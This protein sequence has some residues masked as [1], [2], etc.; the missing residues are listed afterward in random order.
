[1]TGIATK[2]AGVVPAD[3]TDEVFLVDPSIRARRREHVTV[4]VA[5]VAIAVLAL[6]GWQYASGRWIEE[7]WI[8]SPVAVAEALVRFVGAGQ[9]PARDRGDPARDRGRLRRGRRGRHRRRPRASGS[10]R[11]WRG[12]SIPT[13]SR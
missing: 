10:A 7:F 5:R 12:S 8:S 9:L 2:P 1:M 4:L 6:A 11:S 3:G 13:S